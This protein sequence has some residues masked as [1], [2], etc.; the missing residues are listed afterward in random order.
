[1]NLRFTRILPLL[2]VTAILSVG[3]GQNIGDSIARSHIEANVPDEKDFSE[4]LIR[5]LQAYFRDTLKK[6]VRAEYELL[7]EAPTQSGVAYPKFYAWVRVFIDDRLFEEGAVRVAAV[8]KTHF[9]I[10]D[11]LSKHDIQ[12]KPA[13]V[14][15]IFPQALVES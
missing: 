15:T 3:C 10:T 5:D 8:E 7:R 1:M 6:T 12:E 11:Y 13:A 14:E 4:F 2:I 9:E